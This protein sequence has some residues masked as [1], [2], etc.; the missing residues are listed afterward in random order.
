[1]Q[2]LMIKKVRVGSTRRKNEPVRQPMVRKMK[3]R[4]VAKA[5]SFSV[6]PSRSIRIFGAVVFVPTSIPTWHMMPRNDNRTMGVPSSLKHSTNV[7]ALPSMRSSSMGV[8][9]SS[10]VARIP[11]TR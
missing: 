6:M 1:M 8:M 10:S 2:T 11:T 9:P 7:E 3:Y 4:L 5:A